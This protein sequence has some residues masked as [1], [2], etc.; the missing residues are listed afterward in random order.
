M[1]IIAHA[2]DAN[3]LMHITQDYNKIARVVLCGVV[4]ACQRFLYFKNKIPYLFAARRNLQL[5]LN[6]GFTF[7]PT[8]GQNLS[9]TLAYKILPG[10]TSQKTTVLII[11]L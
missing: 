11:R 8:M 3:S 6:S 10:I 4:Q 1:P 9:E 2:E 7:I 5:R